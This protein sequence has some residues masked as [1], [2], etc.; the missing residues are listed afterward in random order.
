MRLPDINAENESQN[1]KGI[2]QP[3][4]IYEQVVPTTQS[5]SVGGI[6]IKKKYLS[7]I[8]LFRTTALIFKTSIF[9]TSDFALYDA[10]T[11]H[12]NNFTEDTMF[13]VR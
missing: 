9:R 11:V 10:H 1:T 3:Q 13:S 5:P 6:T 8:L 7:M 4:S 12:I 2:I